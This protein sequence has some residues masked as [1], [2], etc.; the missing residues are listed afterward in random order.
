MDLWKLNTGVEVQLAGHCL[1]EVVSPTQDGEWVKV[2]YLK[3]PNNPSLEGT[4][5]IC[6]EDE[7]LCTATP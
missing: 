5:D 6:S 2:R 3:V 4:E 7:I 1:A